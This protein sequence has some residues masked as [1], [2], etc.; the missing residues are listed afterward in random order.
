MTIEQPPAL[1][2]A[3]IQPQT[4]PPVAVHVPLAQAVR[5]SGSGLA[6]Q[7]TECRIEPY[8]YQGGACGAAGPASAPGSALGRPARRTP[9]HTHAPA[10]QGGSQSRRQAGDSRLSH[11]RLSVVAIVAWM[12]P[13]GASLT[14][15][16]LSP[17]PGPLTSDRRLR[18]D[19]RHWN[20]ISARK[21]IPFRSSVRSVT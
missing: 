13:S 8:L 21:H 6:R 12:A 9:G 14:S 1:P 20:A 16:T 2:P 7:W 10:D 18:G 4:V 19:S 15:A 3:P 5:L 17:G 11:C